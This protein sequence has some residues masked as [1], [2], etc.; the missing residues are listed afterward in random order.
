ME[1]IPIE[2]MRSGDPKV[3]VTRSEHSPSTGENAPCVTV[4]MS[5]YNAG[6][7][8]AQA[9]QSILEQSFRYFEFLI[10]NDAS[11]D[12]SREIILSFNDPRIVLVDNDN[13]IGLTRSLNK[14]LK[15]ARGKY[16]AR[17]DADDIAMPER[18]QK[19]VGFLES[20]PEYCLVGS[21]FQLYPSEKIMRVPVHDEEIRSLMLFRNTFA[22]P[23]VM[24]R[25]EIVDRYRLYYNEDLLAAQDEELWYRMS[26]YGKMYNLPEILLQYRV[27]PDQISSSRQQLQ[28][29]ISMQIK[30][31]KIKD[32]LDHQ[33]IPDELFYEKWMSDG[34]VVFSP[35][36]FESLKKWI[37][38]IYRHN[39]R[40][41]KVPTK[42]LRICLANLII[43]FLTH[44][45]EKEALIYLKSL[46]LF[47]Q[48]RRIP[49]KFLLKEM[50]IFS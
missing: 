24:F 17:M 33:P 11:T 42:Q 6:D 39:L 3:C 10:I 37:L 15:L 18:L 29:S 45:E 8:L 31:L 26:K 20:H 9:I 27:H 32:F 36:E 25:K 28:Q 43:K 50:G 44:L 19:Q 34:K 47:I 41:R 35:T 23:A 38:L 13:N 48:I 14:G 22:H 30:W 12:R 2:F 21:Y 40:T 49:V 7:Y 4:L 46:F 16:I 1:N 5:V